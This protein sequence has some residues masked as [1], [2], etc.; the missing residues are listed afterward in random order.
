MKMTIPSKVLKALKITGAVLI[1][2][3]VLMFVL[4]LLFPDYITEKVKSFANEKLNG[5]LQFKEAH[6]SF[7]NHFPSL[8]LTLDDFLLKGSEPFKKDTL[9]AAKEVSFGIDVMSLITSSKVN[10]DKIF[11]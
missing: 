1:S 8:T 6:L 4:P 10:I 2:I 7:F 5:E 9:I 11:I 3:L